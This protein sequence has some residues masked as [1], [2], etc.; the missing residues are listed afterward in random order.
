MNYRTLILGADYQ[1]LSVVSWEAAMIMLA[2]TKGDVLEVHDDPIVGANGTLYERPAVIL[3]RRGHAR[4]RRAPRFSRRAVVVRDRSTC[5]Y[6][7]AKLAKSE[8][9][10]DHVVP[11]A[12]GGTSSWTNTVAACFTCNQRKSSRTPAQAGMRLKSQPHKPHELE[13]DLSIAD[14]D[15]LWLPYLSST[16]VADAGAGKS[17]D[18]TSQPITRRRSTQRSGTP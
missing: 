4:R 15:P 12:Q 16:S 2:S 5:M 13:F 8:A 3:L 7:G 10:V 17:A 9:T 14:P 18:E 6:C 11:R 1:P